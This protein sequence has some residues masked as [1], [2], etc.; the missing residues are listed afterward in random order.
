MAEC[1]D[2]V[3]DI[4]A[5]QAPLANQDRVQLWMR[6]VDE[7]AEERLAAGSRE[8]HAR[9]RRRIIRFA[10]VV[11]GLSPEEVFPAGTGR[12]TPR[13][14]IKAWVGSLI[15]QA[16]PP[17][18]ESIR[19]YLGAV[20]QW[21]ISQGLPKTTAPS[22][23]PDVVHALG[24]LGR[25]QAKNGGFVRR[26]VPIST[27]LFTFML[28]ALE[29]QRWPL[30]RQRLM[31]RDRALVA[32][33][34]CGLLRKK[35]VVGL[36]RRDVDIERGAMPHIVL[37]LHGT[38]AKQDGALVR[39]LA[40]QTA[41]GINILGICQAW[42]EELPTDPDTPFFPALTPQG[43][44]VLQDGTLV[45]LSHKSKHVSTRV[46]W[47]VDQA[48]QYAND[49]GA[50]VPIEASLYSSHSLRRG[51]RNAL[52]EAG[53]GRDLRQIFGRWA[54]EVGDSYDQW[55]TEEKLRLTAAIG[56]T[57]GAFQAMVGTATQLR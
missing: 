44:F 39:H 17:A 20:R 40:P 35:E 11:L 41:T 15:C 29:P 31:K 9:T 36:R 18:A 10:E 22:D 6:S 8:E 7:L 56:N 16:K 34:Y 37:R 5:N 43:T 54:S 50:A 24:A 1:P 3:S 23:D 26:A 57:G 30:H 45:Q 42:L 4:L 55:S 46:K 13:W 25:R 48:R 47:I 2:C 14:L 19:N 21:H 32:M 27:A 52:R 51:G 33:A 38:K 28:A 49:L 53:V 12:T